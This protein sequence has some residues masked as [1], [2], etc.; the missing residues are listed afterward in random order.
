MENISLAKN[1]S[2]DFLPEIEL[3]VYLDGK[4]YS[5]AQKNGALSCVWGHRSFPVLGL[6][7]GIFHREVSGTVKW[8]SSE[9]LAKIRIQS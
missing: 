2:A 9:S 7:Q 3:Y 6:F 5:R 1:F 4:T 8:D